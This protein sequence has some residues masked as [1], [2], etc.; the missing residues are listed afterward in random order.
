MSQ[1]TEIFNESVLSTPGKEV[2][3]AGMEKYLSPRRH[4]VGP[5]H[6]P[7]LSRPL[8]QPKPDLAGILP[9]TNLMQNFLLVSNLPPESF[10]AK[11]PHLLK[12]LPALMGSS[13]TGRRASDG[14]GYQLPTNSRFESNLSSSYWQGAGS[15]N[16]FEPQLFDIKS[17]DRGSSRE[18]SPNHQLVDQYLKSRG[19]V[20]RHTIPELPRKRRTGLHTVM[21]KPPTIT[22]ELVEEVESRIKSQSP[23]SQ[24]HLSVPVS[25]HGNSKHKSRQ[26]GLA[27]LME[28]GKLSHFQGVSD[29]SDPDESSASSESN[30]PQADLNIPTKDRRASDSGV[31]LS[32]NCKKSSLKVKI[33]CQ[34]DPR[35]P[36]QQLYQEMYSTEFS[37]SS[38]RRYSYPNSPVHLTLDKSNQ[39]TKLSNCLEQLKLEKKTQPELNLLAA[40]HA[41]INCELQSET[42][43]KGSI[44]QGVPSRNTAR[45]IE[46]NNESHC[47]IMP[48]IIS[49]SKSFDENFG[50][51]PESFSPLW[52]KHQPTCSHYQVNKAVPCLLPCICLTKVTGD[53]ILLY[54]NSE[55]MDQ[56]S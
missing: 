20:K 37:G 2:S 11:D 28:V 23:Y 29:S 38:S 34:N 17:E 54:E 8:L 21:E 48:N 36:I 47:Q 7:L 35:E 52:G 5:S 46:L 13:S 25:L 41:G 53:E 18:E 16:Q 26:A 10:S 22:P 19:Q 42:R 30:C 27:P 43:W 1:I 32:L 56:S 6:K 49:Q 9:Q 12:P 50:K 40:T 33:P 3:L 55:P 15:Q 14:G 39:S 24:N 4:T 31:K 45:P 44:T 51:H